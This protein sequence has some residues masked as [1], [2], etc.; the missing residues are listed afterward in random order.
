MKSLNF[1]PCMSLHEA[2]RIAH[3][4]GL[5]L[6]VRWFGEECKVVAFKPMQDVPDFLKLQAS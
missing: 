2:A 5:E 1:I 4:N 3:E 6:H